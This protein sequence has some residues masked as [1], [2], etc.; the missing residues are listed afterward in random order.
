MSY[1][2]KAEPVEEP[3]HYSPET[4][5]YTIIDG[6]RK[7][8]VYIVRDGVRCFAVGDHRGIAGFKPEAP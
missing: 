5:S 8:Q 2:A 3:T 6:P 7:G 4:G 1:R